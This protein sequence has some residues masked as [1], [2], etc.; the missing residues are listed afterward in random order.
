MKLAA[1][2]TILFF[3]SA[4]FA[5]PSSAAWAL[6]WKDC[7]QLPATQQAETRYGWLSE[8]DGKSRRRTY[9]ANAGLINCLSKSRRIV[10]PAIIMADGSLA[11]WQDI[12]EA[13]WSKAVLI[14]YTLS[15]YDQ[16]PQQWDKLS[17]PNLEPVFHVFTLI[18]Y[19]D[20]STK[21]V[22]AIAPWMLQPL[23]GEDNKEAV[24]GLIKATGSQVP[25]VEARNFV[26]QTAIDFDR[27]AG[28]YG[29]LG[30]KDK[31]SFDKLVRLDKNVQP[32]REAVAVSGVA[33]ES[34]AIER[35][36]R[37]GYWITFDQV[38][39]RAQGNRNPLVQMDRAKFQFDASEIFA[40]LDNGL[41][42]T[43][44]FSSKGE[45]QQSAPDGVGYNHKSIT[46]DG[47]IH[48]NLSCLA[49]H[50][51]GKGN[52]GLKPFT[53]YFRTLYAEPGPLALGA[54]KLLAPFDEQY[55]S[56]LEK[57]ADIDKR[58][59]IASMLEANG[60]EPSEYATA[61]YQTFASWDEPL[62]INAAAYEH[63][64]TTEA[65]VELLQA[66]IVKFGTLDNVSAN[67]LLPPSRRMKIPRNQFA[68]SFN[69]TQL[70]IRGYSTWP[71]EVKKQI[72][73]PAVP[74]IQTPTAP[75]NKGR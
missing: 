11:K 70:A 61:L 27:P 6:A 55:L 71:T 66:A 58:L 2:L 17:D 56:S 30:I 28:Y 8:N 31:A 73:L 1:T 51:S 5:Q 40:K 15:N 43:G 69:L 45:L 49:C 53:P 32:F 26:W 24:I 34:R 54:A 18:P 63:G 25:I 75:V 14:R 48:V 33:T 59:Y 47:K 65:L 60:M 9:A 57:W 7:K 16:T 52:G 20:G 42:A 39:Q 46:N 12:K 21:K 10:P 62:D 19:S 44:L 36:D 3:A 68:E 23:S 41:W 13:D 4:V 22:R 74:V 37:L 67:W 50:D 64:V 72:V 35:Q 38:N 29:W